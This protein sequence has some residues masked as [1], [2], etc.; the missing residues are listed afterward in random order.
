[1]HFSAFWIAEK[2]WVLQSLLNFQLLCRI[3]IL[4]LCLRVTVL[5]KESNRHSVPLSLTEAASVSPMIL[6]TISF[7]VFL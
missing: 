5:S 6:F 3:E 4:A 1:M 2:A 7:G